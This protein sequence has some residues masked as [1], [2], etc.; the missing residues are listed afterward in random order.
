M[1][2][3]AVLLHWNR[4]KSEP[5]TVHCTLLHCAALTFSFSF[6][7]LFSLSLSFSL[8]FHF[9]IHAYIHFHFFQL[10]YHR[11]KY[12]FSNRKAKLEHHKCLLGW[13]IFEEVEEDMVCKGVGGKVE[14]EE[15]N[16]LGKIKK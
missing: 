15:R 14:G 4:A 1:V 6:S 7:F 8:S 16:R 13:R 5:T 12:T 2:W 11:S 3:C 10:R 9:Y